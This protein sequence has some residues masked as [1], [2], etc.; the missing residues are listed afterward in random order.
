MLLPTG[1]SSRAVWRGRIQCRSPA[2]RSRRW[3]YRWQYFYLWCQHL[4]RLPSDG[5]NGNRADRSRPINAGH[6]LRH[7]LHRSPGDAGRVFCL[8][9]CMCLALHARHWTSGE[10]GGEQRTRFW[11]LPPV[12]YYSYTGYTSCCRWVRVCVCESQKFL[13]KL[14]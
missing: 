3:Y 4:L 8:H 10:L 13:N 6:A 2:C 11:P 5:D 7:E 12:G 9:R 1:R 14:F